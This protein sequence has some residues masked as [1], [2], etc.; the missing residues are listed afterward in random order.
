MPPITD[1]VRGDFRRH[2]ELV[3][4]PSIKSPRPGTIEPHDTN[5][6]GYDT[7]GSPERFGGSLKIDGSFSA[8]TGNG[9][10]IIE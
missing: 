2:R 6:E 5:T 1:R 4:K 3:V 7:E 9:V 8:H 10:K